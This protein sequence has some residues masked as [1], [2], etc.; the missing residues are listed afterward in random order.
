MNGKIDAIQD[1]GELSAYFTRERDQCSA[2]SE[3]FIGT[4]CED[5]PPCNIFST[6]FKQC[7]KL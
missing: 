3:N 4:C 6:F 1:C 7:G 5:P 2:F